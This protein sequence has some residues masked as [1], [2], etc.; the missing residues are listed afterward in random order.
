MMQAGWFCNRGSVEVAVTFGNC[1]YTK[2]HN[3]NSNVFIAIILS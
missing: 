3:C 2:Y 1:K